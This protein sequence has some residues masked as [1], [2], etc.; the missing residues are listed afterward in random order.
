MKKYLIITAALLCAMC[1]VGQTIRK[2]NTFSRQRKT[3]ERDTLVTPYNFKAKGK[4]YPIVINKY[5]GA[6]YIWRKS[7]NGKCYRQYMS[8]DIKETVCKELKIKSK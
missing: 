4:T 7:K 6:C 1:A 2:G 8:K 5:T 3:T